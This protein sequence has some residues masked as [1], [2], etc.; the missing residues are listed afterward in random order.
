MLSFLEVSYQLGRGEQT[1]DSPLTT[2]KF[3][4]YDK[5]GAL[6]LEIEMTA[7]E[8]KKQSH[9]LTLTEPVTKK[10]L[11]KTTQTILNEIR[12]PQSN[13]KSSGQQ[14]APKS[15]PEQQ[16]EP[17]Q[18]SEQQSTQKS[19]PAQQSEPPKTSQEQKVN[20]HV[21]LRDEKPL[22]F[23]VSMK[24]EDLAN[25]LAQKITEPLIKLIQDSLEY[26]SPIEVLCAWA[27]HA[28]DA[29]SK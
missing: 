11:L 15:E 13:Q 26:G 27:K 12:K 23:K 2:F 18:Q 16:L 28:V 9:D 25:Q 7:T 4:K 3:K 20:I 21:L 17:K 10:D 8:E 1:S 22:K 24:E 29:V 19:K 6:E 14:S 5:S